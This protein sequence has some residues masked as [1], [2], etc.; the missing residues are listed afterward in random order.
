MIYR[1]GHVLVQGEHV[2]RV[3]S[4]RDAV[5]K[6]VGPVGTKRRCG[7]ASNGWKRHVAE[8]SLGLCQRIDVGGSAGRVQAVLS[9]KPSGERRLRGDTEVVGGSLVV[10]VLSI[11]SFNV[12]KCAKGLLLYVAHFVNLFRPRRRG[13]TRRKTASCPPFIDLAQQGISL[14]NHAA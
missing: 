12:Q 1:V 14:G 7:G 8:Q 4:V 6:V 2:V 13:I 5:R 11:F 10:I 9:R 3:L